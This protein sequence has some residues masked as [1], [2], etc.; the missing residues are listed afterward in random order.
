M[1]EPIVIRG[2]H[3]I[4]GSG[5][6]AAGVSVTITSPVNA[7]METGRP[8]ARVLSFG[9]E[10]YGATQPRNQIQKASGE[11]LFVYLDVTDLLRSAVEPL[12]GSL[13]LEEVAEIGRDLDVK[14]GVTS[15]PGMSDHS[16]LR[17][18]SAGGRSYVRLWLTGGTDGTDYTGIV[19]ITT[20]STQVIEARFLLAVRDTNED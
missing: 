14:N 9:E 4:D 17:I 12:A 20:T 13:A 5:A 15:N 19:P 10:A 2:G 8:R 1:T 6:P 7:Y 3:V 11:S 16:K 18:L